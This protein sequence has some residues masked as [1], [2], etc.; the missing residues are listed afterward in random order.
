MCSIFTCLKFLKERNKMSWLDN[1]RGFREGLRQGIPKPIRRVSRW[2]NPLWMAEQA[3]GSL[4]PGPGQTGGDYLF[5]PKVQNTD[6]P[7]DT[8]PIST[9]TPTTTSTTAPSTQYTTGGTT[10]NEW[11]PTVFLGVTYNTLEEY[12]AAVNTEATRLYEAQKATLDRA[13]DTG[14]LTFK[15]REKQL[16][17]NAENL[18]RA[19]DNTLKNQAGF[20]QAVSPDVSQS[21]QGDYA[22]EAQGEYTRGVEN[23]NDSSAFLQTEKSNY[24]A[25][26]LDS[27]AELEKTYQTNRDAL[28]NQL[29]SFGATPTVSKENTYQTDPKSI[30]DSF[31]KLNLTQQQYGSALPTRGYTAKIKP[32]APIT[33][34]LY[35]EEATK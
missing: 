1:Y 2:F 13:Y 29:I 16:Q 9:T 27:I 19:R 30:L 20:F 12:E 7:T 33:T 31:N 32:L 11:E 14:M 8:Q 22:Q 5:A 18:L 24:V 3:I 10:T 34:A 28:A 35:P 21:A 15:D 6:T 23:I 26:V 25:S 17:T 4:I